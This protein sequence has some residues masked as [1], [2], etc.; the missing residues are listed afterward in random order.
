MVVS[1]YPG[2]LSAWEVQIFSPSAA[3]QGATGE[4]RKAVWSD[5]VQYIHGAHP[6]LSP[7]CHSSCEF[8]KREGDACTSKHVYTRLQTLQAHLITMKS[9]IVSMS[10]S[11]A[12]FAAMMGGN[13]SMMAPIPPPPPAFYPAPMMFPYGMVTDRLQIC[14]DFM[15]DQCNIL[16]CPLVHPGTSWHHTVINE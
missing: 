1:A 4:C 15:M 10:Q 7:D 13:G 11:Q 5:D 14:P 2:S 3:H 6:S 8:W 12:G 9:S 16:L